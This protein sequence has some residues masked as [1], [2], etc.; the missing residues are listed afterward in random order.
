[1]T[2][3]YFNLIEGVFWLCLGIVSL[4]MY[5]KVEKKYQSLALFSVLIF[6]TFGV[7][8]FFQAVYGSFLIQGME[9]LF[10]WKIIDVIGLC[11]IPLWYLILR[12]R[13]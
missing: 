8:D 2:T 9:W 3:E 11:A 1:M 5:F 13:E 12:I 6:C 7:S 10:I 4:F